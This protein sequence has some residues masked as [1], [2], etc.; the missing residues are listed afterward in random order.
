MRSICDFKALMNDANFKALMEEHELYKDIWVTEAEFHNEKN[1]ASALKG[2]Q[3]AGASK[4]FFT[5]LEIG[6]QGPPTNN[7]SPVYED[8]SSHCK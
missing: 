8:I 1:V 3:D 5:Q 6:H 7:Y 4:V 2:A